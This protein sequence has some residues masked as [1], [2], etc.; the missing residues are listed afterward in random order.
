MRKRVKRLNL[1]TTKRSHDKL[2]LNNLFTSF[3][4]YGKVVTTERKARALKS[5]A[6]SQI[7]E[8]STIS[9][10]RLK[11]RW[12]NVNIST[13]KLLKKATESLNKL[14]SAKVSMARLAPRKGDNA[15]R[16]EVSTLNLVQTTP[17]EPDNNAKK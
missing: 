13:G 7:H 8:Y 15:A 12:I 11:K 1:N 3:V 16:Y 4:L 9:D 14:V 10:S 2:L 5:F 17:N 6:Q